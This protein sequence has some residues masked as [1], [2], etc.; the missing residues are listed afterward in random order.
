MP[1][2]FSNLSCK[3]SW[4]SMVGS[5]Q[6]VCVYCLLFVVYQRWLDHLDDHAEN[7]RMIFDSETAEKYEKKGLEDRPD[8]RYRL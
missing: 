1:L 4:E 7:L 6:N 3:C 5:K 8:C 2:S